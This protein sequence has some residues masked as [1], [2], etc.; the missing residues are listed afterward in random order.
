MTTEY[1]TV[2]FDQVSFRDSSKGKY[3]FFQQSDG[4]ATCIAD[5][6]FE[7]HLA[8]EIE[9]AQMGIA[10]ELECETP[11][12]PT[13]P[14]Q[15]RLNSTHYMNRAVNKALEPVVSTP[16][17][18]ETDL[19]GTKVT[20]TSSADNRRLLGELH[21]RA[22]ESDPRCQT[23]DGFMGVFVDNQLEAYRWLIPTEGEIPF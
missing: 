2:S 13:R 22:K 3:I 5:I 6:A 10:V 15:W 9:K 12:K 16:K 19:R 23:F 20:Y 1:T 4:L 21:K 8:A 7:E 17:P 18:A 11:R 14:H